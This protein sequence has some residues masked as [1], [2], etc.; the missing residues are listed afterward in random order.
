MTFL[1]QNVAVLFGYAK[2]LD[3]CAYIEKLE[4]PFKSNLDLLECDGVEE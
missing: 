4:F 1:L 2:N 3:L